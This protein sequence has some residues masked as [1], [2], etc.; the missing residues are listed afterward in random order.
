[1]GW[2]LEDWW[3]DDVN[4]VGTLETGMTHSPNGT[5]SHSMRIL[6]PTV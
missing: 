5:K 2:L 6:H 1:M 3:A 4:T